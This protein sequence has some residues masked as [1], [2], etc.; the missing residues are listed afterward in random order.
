MNY[1][2]R[3]TPTSLTLARNN[4]AVDAI[5]VR[6]GLEAMTV[7]EAVQ[8]EYEV[9]MKVARRRLLEVHLRQELR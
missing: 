8:R 9:A 2:C 4:E 6:A 7:P 5:V 3:L 1:E